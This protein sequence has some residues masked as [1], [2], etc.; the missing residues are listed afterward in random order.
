METT[1]TIEPKQKV[2]FSL[3]TSPHLHSK[4]TTSKVMWFVAAALLPS[5]AAA[6]TFFGWTQIFIILIAVVFAVGTEVSI[7]AIRKKQITWFDGSAALTGLLLALTLPPNFSLSATAI[8]SVVAIGLGKQIFGGLGYNIFNPALVGRAF[9]QAAFPVQITTWTKPNFAVDSVTSATPLAAL[10]FD[11]IFTDTTAM[12]IGN[13]G[14]SLG[15]T[16]A[17]AVLIG[18]IILIAA[19]IVNWRIPFSMI[20]GMILFGG[21]FWL[22]D[23]QNPTPVFHIFAGSFLFG[24]MFMAT[25]WVTSPITNKGMW[26]FGFGISLVLIVIRIY[27]GLPEGVM[28][29]ILFM[30]GFV[31]LINRYTKPVIFGVVKEVKNK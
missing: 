3:T 16:S 27:G 23:P 8:G 6:L 1:T 9:L 20:I 7:Q 15:E 4:W 18:G 22:I 28:Y 21:I 14:G 12:T 13:I 10:K 5:I 11:K 26:I 2:Y 19:G 25:D 17:I 29:S 24:A 31:P 30:N